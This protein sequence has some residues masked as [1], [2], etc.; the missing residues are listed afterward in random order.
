VEFS[1]LAWFVTT[2]VVVVE[3]LVSLCEGTFSRLQNKLPRIRLSFLWHWAVS[4]GDLIILPV[5]NGFVASH[6][7]FSLWQWGALLLASLVVTL[8][9]H[10]AWWPAEQKALGF[11]YPDWNGSGKE[12]KFWYRDLSLAGW[13]HVEFMT[14][15]LA[16]IVGY[17]LT[18]MPADIVQLVGVIFLIFVPFGVIEPGVVEGWPLSKEKKLA[19]FGIAVALWLIVIG[20]TWIKM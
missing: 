8:A 10:Y 14:V 7:H 16:V 2:I 17:I 1:W 18:P 11:I 20:A 3:G 4:I 12:R 6:L 9:C 5:F 19:T 15:Q 13:V